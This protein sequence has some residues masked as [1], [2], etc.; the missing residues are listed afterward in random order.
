MTCPSDGDSQ[1]GTFCFPATGETVLGNVIQRLSLC[2]A[3]NGLNQ[4]TLQFG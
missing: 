4:Q 1:G 2:H 3:L